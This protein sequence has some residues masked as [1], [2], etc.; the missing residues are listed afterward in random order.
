MLRLLLRHGRHVAIRVVHWLPARI[1]LLRVEGRRRAMVEG[2][3]VCVHGRLRRRAIHVAVVLLLAARL[4]MVGNGRGHRVAAR[5]HVVVHG[6]AARVELCSNQAALA[7]RPEAPL[8]RR[9]WRWV[10]AVR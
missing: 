9:G 6:D 4:L 1:L 5:A 2:V 10:G 8:G 7:I 3:R